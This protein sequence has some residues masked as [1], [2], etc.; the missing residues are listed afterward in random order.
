MKNNL[1]NQTNSLKFV[2]VTM[3][4]IMQ[5]T[6]IEMKLWPTQCAYNSYLHA[7]QNGKP[8]WIVYDKNEIV[9]ISGI[10]EYPE[11]GKNTAWLG[12][13][14]VVE[15]KRGYGY[16]KRILLQTLSIAKNQG[17]NCLRLYSS[18]DN[19]LCPN[20]IPFYEKL[21]VQ[22]NGFVEDYTLE[23]KEMQR[24]VVS[25]SLDGKEISKWN[26]R[27]LHLVNDEIDEKN[28]YKVYSKQLDYI[29]NAM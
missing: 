3:Q 1:E 18:R 12:W 22:F 7:Y 24:V 16:G 2:P 29:K 6:A 23:Q 20:A 17:F 8:Y 9:G 25:F 14:G 26:N 15:E 13:F 11:L 5:A 4:N 21:S 28:G 27:C 10:Y 19:N